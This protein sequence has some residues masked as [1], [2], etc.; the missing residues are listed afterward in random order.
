MNVSARVSKMVTAVISTCLIV[1]LVTLTGC[2]NTTYSN[3]LSAFDGSTYSSLTVAHS[4]LNT[5]RT[6]ILTNHPKYVGTF[7]EAATAY[8]TAF[9]TYSLYRANPSQTQAQVAAEIASLTVGIVALENSIESDLPVPQPQ[10]DA[11]RARVLHTKQR[12]LFLGHA[13]TNITLAD[14]LS[15]LA[16][17][18]EIAK[19]VPG[20]SKY[21]QLAG[22]VIQAAQNATAALGSAAG[23][24]IDLG[25]IQ[26]VALIPVG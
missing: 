19:L 3:Q 22:I 20:A 15:D 17:A 1:A 14:I 18:A 23:K 8:V 6:E 21:G 13:Q 12:M 25:T 5:L 10:K 16:I 24:P 2:G 9:N 26:P 4:A 7:N 11:M